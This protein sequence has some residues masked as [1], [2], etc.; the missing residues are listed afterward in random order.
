VLRLGF[1]FLPLALLIAQTPLPEDAARSSARTRALER[2]TRTAP[3]ADSSATAEYRVAT[4]ILC[5]NGWESGIVLLNT[6]ADPL[7]FQQFF[8]SP[9]G[10]P[11]IFN[12][13]SEPGSQ[14]LQTSAIQGNLNPNSSLNLALC[15]AGGAVR[16]GWSLI[17]YLPGHGVLNGYTVIRHQGLGGMLNFE[18]ISPLS[19]MSDFAL[20]MPFDNTKGFRSQLTLLN[21]ANISASVR[22]TCVDRQGQVLLVDVLTLQPAHQITLVLPDAYPDLANKSGTVLVGADINRLSVTGLQ[23]NEA[24]GTIEALPGFSR[25]APTTQ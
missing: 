14:D 4:R 15:D 11:A 13:R 20:S 23:Y 25:S 18:T 7:T 12:V 10:S 22:L 19:A 1:L 16:E 21:P 9:D 2:R 5:G 17:G 8:F 3:N 6:G 24:Y